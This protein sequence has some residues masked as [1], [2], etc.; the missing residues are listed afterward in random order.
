MYQVIINSVTA[1]QEKGL[2]LLLC[3]KNQ[4]SIDSVTVNLQE[5]IML[6]LYGL[7]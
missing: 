5:V 4:V 1:N 2:M 6:V 7:K 3:A